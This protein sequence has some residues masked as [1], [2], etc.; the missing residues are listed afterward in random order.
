METAAQL[1]S[2]ISSLLPPRST[3]SLES[4]NLTALPAGVWWNFRSLL[5]SELR[6]SGILM[7]ATQP[8]SRAGPAPTGAALPRVRLTLSDNARGWLLVAEVS[9][10]DNRRIAMLAWNPPSSAQAKA[11]VTV[12]KKALWAQPEPIL[13]VLLL[14]GD[15]EM[16]V[17]S[18]KTVA[19]YRAAG[20][21]WTPSATASLLLARPM[22][23]DPRGRFE[24]T[25]DGFRVY[26]P[27]AT[28]QG[29]WR[30]ELKLTCRNG[31]ETWP[32]AQVRWVADRNVLESSAVKSS[33]V[34]AAFYSFANGAGEE[35]FA[36]ADGRAEDPAGQPVA[37]AEGWG[38][39]IAGIADPCGSPAAVVASGTNSDREEVRVYQVANG[40]ATPA[41]DAIPFTG[42]V[43]ALWPAGREAMVVARNLQTGEYESSRL[44]LA[45]TE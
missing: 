2:R 18:T 33:A 36:R 10:G 7:E 14:D 29:V 13:D 21:K 22:P 40:Q 20:D 12:T 4:Q 19:S 45:C 16:L 38:S 41:S 17:L 39:D 31:T 23:R 34:E 8:E 6:K 30:P 43:T 42:P 15:A 27:V 28:C 37:G 25:A 9:S 35:I 24:A 3:V 5:Q 32:D 26:L 1:A 44:L 11:G